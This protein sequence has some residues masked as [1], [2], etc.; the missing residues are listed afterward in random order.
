M[1]H[2][3]LESNKGLLNYLVDVKTNTFDF[4]EHYVLMLTI[5]TH[6]PHKTHFQ[7]TFAL[8]NKLHT[9]PTIDGPLLKYNPLIVD[10]PF[11]TYLTTLHPL[12]TM[13]TNCCSTLLLSV[14]ELSRALIDVSRLFQLQTLYSSYKHFGF[15]GR[16][17]TRERR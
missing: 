17:E 14:T 11:T 1:N 9:P 6:K 7:H 15:V 13:F 8:N 4:N 10:N 3:D 16:Q 2:F 12:T 5:I